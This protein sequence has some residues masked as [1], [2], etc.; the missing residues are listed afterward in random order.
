VRGVRNFFISATTRL[1]TL[2]T[3]PLRQAAEGEDRLADQRS[4]APHTCFVV[5]SACCLDL[6]VVR[7]GGSGEVD[8]VGRHACLAVLGQGCGA[9]ASR[10][11]R[12][13][14]PSSAASSAVL[15]GLRWAGLPSNHP[16]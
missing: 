5:A 11:R 1:F 9:P 12:H 7:G 3:V 2:L 8:E 14:P 13:G 4:L 15:G 6:P 16:A 10:L